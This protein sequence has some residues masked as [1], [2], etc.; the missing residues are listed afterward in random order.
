MSTSYA[1]DKLTTAIKNHLLNVDAAPPTA[2]VT[3]LAGE[4]AQVCLTELDT[5]GLASET[6]ENLVAPYAFKTKARGAD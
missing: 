6:I 4:L 1:K 2:E 5:A 3:K